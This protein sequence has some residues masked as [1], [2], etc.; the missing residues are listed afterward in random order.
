MDLGKSRASSN[1]NTVKQYV[2]ELIL[3][4]TNLLYCSFSARIKQK[5][6]SVAL[7]K[8][9]NKR[10]KKREETKKRTATLIYTDIAAV[11]ISWTSSCGA[12]NIVRLRII[13]SSV[14]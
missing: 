12:R 4:N 10:K 3:R 2:S 1:L 8:K 7:L 5:R 11:T 9:A 14:L 6:K 13:K